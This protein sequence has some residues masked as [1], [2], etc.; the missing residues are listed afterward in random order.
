MRKYL[1]R[2]KPHWIEQ[3][4]LGN[5]SQVIDCWLYPD[6]AYLETYERG[7][8]VELND[9]IVLFPSEYLEGVQS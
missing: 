6:A 4:N 2:L 1:G 7:I 8:R 5:R 3:W 9:P